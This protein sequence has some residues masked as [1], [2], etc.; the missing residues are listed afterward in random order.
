M[1]TLAASKAR[2]FMVGDIREYPVIASD[3]IF[4]GAAVGENDSGYARPL[5]AG[6]AFLGFAEADA[7]NTSGSAGDI[8]VRVKIRGCV[9]LPISTGAITLNDRQA[10]YASDDNAFTVTATSNSLIGYASQW[11]ATG[12]VYVD[13]DAVLVKAALQA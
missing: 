4:E 5:V 7:D 6:D 9:E 11:V 8:N 2:K 1:T 12:Y 13:F 3:K 10:I